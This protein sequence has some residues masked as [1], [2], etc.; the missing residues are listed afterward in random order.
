MSK[1]AISV[2]MSTYCRA[3]IISNS[4]SSILNQTF[5]DLELIIIDDGSKDGTKEIIEN[6]ASKDDRIRWVRFEE[7]SGTPALRYNQGMTLAKGEYIA[8][9]FDDDEWYLDALEILHD[10]IQQ[11]LD[12]GMIYG[13]ADYIDIRTNK[14]IGKGFGA[15][16]D[17]ER[18]VKQ[19][20]FLCNNTVLVKKSVINDVGG[21]DEEPVLKRLCDWDLWVR[22]GEKYKVRRI[23]KTV[24]KVNAFYGD[25]IGNTIDLNITK[26][27][28][29]QAN[30]N[31]EI[32]LRNYWSEKK[33]IF[34]LT[35]G[36]DA[37]L[38]RWRIDYLMNAVNDLD[39]RWQI[40]KYDKNEKNYYE[41]FRADVIVLYRFLIG[42]SELERLKSNKI[43][44]YDIDDY[45]FEEFGK[46][47]TV[48]ERRHCLN[49]IK[50][51]VKV[52]VASKYLSD[53]IPFKDKSY[54]RSNG[55][56]IKEF[57]KL[58][59]VKKLSDVDLLRIGWL[60]GINRNE[61]NDFVISLLERI[62][63]KY[64]IRFTYFGKT[65]V[66]YNQLKKINNLVIDRKKYAPVDNPTF[67][68]QTVLD[69]NLDFIINPLLRDEFFEYKSELK[70]LEAGI[71]KVPLITSP[72]GMFK[73]I[74]KHGENGFLA[75]SLDEFEETI[76][77]IV[78]NKYILDEIKNNAYKYVTTYY[79]IDHIR[80]Q[81]IIFL[82]DVY[83]NNNYVL[84]ESPSKDFYLIGTF[85]GKATSVVGEIFGNKRIIQSFIGE[86]ND[87]TKIQILLATYIRR[88]I[89]SL[90]IS[91]L[92]DMNNSKSVI[93]KTVVD[94]HQIIDN[95][96][97]EF[98]FDPI[99]D[100]KGKRY[101]IQLMGIK[102]SSGS[103]VTAYYN[104]QGNYANGELWLNKSKF[105]G[106][107]CF[108]LY[109]LN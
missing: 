87:L 57:K 104:A 78:A 30:K 2:V 95:E 19:G 12:C 102:C 71:L 24:G 67:F 4:I 39:A 32:P 13:L 60:G 37:A 70:F 44:I 33:Q 46:Y 10:F 3:R 77:Y 34:F 106:S 31:R 50:K 45:V 49:W 96:W 51:A 90:E 28:N 97:F 82:D 8:F 98:Q 83:K 80:D 101:Y 42:D 88:N 92:T 25:S 1:P 5:E 55:L 108:K 65:D 27:R 29:H 103:A 61:N 58:D 109:Y 14:Y 56:P 68:Y 84:E 66:F 52:T 91:I 11:N 35:H 7:N 64:K 63:E 9:M 89:G 26:I 99:R 22:I 105:K 75:E 62:T 73:D 15:E 38:K 85:I 54:V 93:R 18:L 86:Y 69:S 6:F 21:Y 53:V 79:N 74:I 100:S 94:C 17:Y 76:D 20:N 43:L 47:N 48:Y 81:Y 41:M 36:H 72:R 107:L 40:S 23:E 16:W 59:Y